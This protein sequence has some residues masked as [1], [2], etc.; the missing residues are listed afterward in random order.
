MRLR[1]GFI[2]AAAL[3]GLAAT[4]Q[5]ALAAPHDGQWSVLVVTER[6]NCEVYRWDFA[7]R[8]GRVSPLGDAA[9]RASGKVSQAGR[10]NVTFSRGSDRLSATGSV[11]ANSGSGRWSSPTRQCQGRWSAEKRG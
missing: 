5:T 6:G 7:V 9:T 1:T 11:D 8:N 2:G 3:I 4:G 10:L